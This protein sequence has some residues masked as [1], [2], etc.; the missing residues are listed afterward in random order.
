MG[1]PSLNQPHLAL[2][3]V[4]IKTDD[5]KFLAA[6]VE[7]TDKNTRYQMLSTLSTWRTVPPLPLRLP[8]VQNKGG[9]KIS[10]VLT[11]EIKIYKR[12]KSDV[13]KPF[14]LHFP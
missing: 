4:K 6:S 14:F 5:G 1:A 10:T 3:S 9:G 11:E 13:N 7:K 8:E 12:R 2:V